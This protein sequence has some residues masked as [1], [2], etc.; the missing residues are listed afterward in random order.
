MPPSPKV[1]DHETTV[2]SESVEASVK[3][4]VSPIAGLGGEKVNAA[5]GGR[6]VG[7]VAVT[8]MLRSM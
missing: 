4:T 5:V 6:L 2:P 1:Q 3:V 7:G 8:V